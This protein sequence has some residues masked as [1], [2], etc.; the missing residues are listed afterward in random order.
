MPTKK[1]KVKTK[2]NK[3]SFG[4]MWYAYGSITVY[5]IVINEKYIAMDFQKQILAYHTK[6]EAEQ[7]KK[8]MLK[9]DKFW[10][11]KRDVQIEK[12]QLA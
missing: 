10:G 7:V 1:A 2:E 5:V 8:M 11:I 12:K 9:S 3:I 6:K 4:T